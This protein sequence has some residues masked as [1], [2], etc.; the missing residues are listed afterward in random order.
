MRLLAR[1]LS[2]ALLLA[3][4]A[5][6][7]T[8]ASA[9]GGPPLGP[10]PVAPPPGPTRTTP[11]PLVSA[12]GTSVPDQYIVTLDKDVNLTGAARTLDIK[13]LFTYGK[14]MHGFA[15]VLTASQLATV[16]NT[17]G[18]LAVE[19]NA[20][21]TDFDRRIGGPRGGAGGAQP[22]VTA[23]SWGL[24]RIDQHNLPL[25]NQFSTLGHGAG[26]T[27]YIVDTGID[28]GHSEFGGR[29]VPGFDAIGDGRDG[30]D[31]AGHG[32]HVAGTVGGAT[33]GVA[34][35]AS[36][37]SVRVLDCQGSGTLAGVIAGF[38]WVADNAKQPAVVN[39][40]LGG[41]YSPALNAAADALADSGV[42]PVVAAGNSTEDACDVSP[43]SAGEALTVGAS[44]RTDQETSFSNYGSCLSMFAPG[45]A[46]VSAKLGGGSIAMDGTSMASPHVAG[47]ALLYKA[48]HPSATAADVRTWLDDNAT[49]NVLSGV[50]DSPNRLLF[51]GGL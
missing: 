50:Q 14:V 29:A 6:L 32:T 49:E 41:G 3:P 23:A 40:S 16:R 33:F 37:V 28:Y 1:G 5:L 4:L 30:A 48:A 17:P 12:T 21:V 35:Q 43:A 47:A 39:A 45:Q 8:A 27:A 31:C 9:A 44:N 26:A 11:A 20:Q 38:D 25:D 13:P 24:D 18:V 10:G 19:Q 42:L 51:T 2:A 36:L 22:R 46:I 15:A 34:P 7:P